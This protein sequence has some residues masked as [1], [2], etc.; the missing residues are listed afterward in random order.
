MATALPV[1]ATSQS[2]LDRSCREVCSL[3]YRGQPVFQ[4]SPHLPDSA[5]RPFPL[6]PDHYYKWADGRT[7]VRN[8]PALIRDGRLI[9]QGDLIRGWAADVPL[10]EFGRTR[11]L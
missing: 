1:E 8:V 11:M 5:Q 7:E 2:Y 9:W 10:D 3:T 4:L 6:S